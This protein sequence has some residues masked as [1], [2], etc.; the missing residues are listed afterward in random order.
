MLKLEKKTI[1]SEGKWFEYS[2]GV[3][4]KIRPLTGQTMK[5][6]RKGVSIVKMEV[7][8]GRKMIPVEH[9]DD[10]KLEDALAEHLIE[11]FK[12]IGGSENTALPVNLES[13]KL[14]LDQI[15]I[16][17]FV[18]NSAQSLDIEADQIKNS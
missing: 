17:E 18:W 4:I 5:E 15:P 6:I 1:E 7:G 11:D 10:D 3:E 16:R 8:P 13:K 14:I 2:E 9:T 12:G